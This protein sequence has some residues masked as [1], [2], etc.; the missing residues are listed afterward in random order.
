MFVNLCSDWSQDVGD[1]SVRELTEFVM[2]PLPPPTGPTRDPE[3]SVMAAE[4]AGLTVTDLREFR[5]LMEF[6]D[7][8]AVV[9]FLIQAR[10]PFH[11][12]G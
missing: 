4:R 2:G 8:A 10:R 7:V 12:H 11:D 9:H 6:N 1:G 3:W 5:G